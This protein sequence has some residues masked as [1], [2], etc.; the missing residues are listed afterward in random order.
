MGEFQV[1]SLASRREASLIGFVLKLLDGGGRGMLNDFIPII[2]GSKNGTKIQPRFDPRCTTKQYDRSIEGQLSNV[3]SKIPNELLN[4]EG[5]D[6]WQ[7][8]TK[9]CQRFL[10]GK[11]LRKSRII[12]Q[13]CIDNFNSKLDIKCNVSFN[14][15]LSNP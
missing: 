13:Q 9:N 4:L 3:W 1:E 15:P 8:H 5:A 12:K 10:T 6:E 11:K 14:K 2:T 7:K